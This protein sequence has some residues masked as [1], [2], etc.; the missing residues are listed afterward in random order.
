MSLEDT[1]NSKKGRKRKD[2]SDSV[3]L[4]NEGDDVSPNF[5]GIA[6]D[7]SAKKGKSKESSRSRNLSEDHAH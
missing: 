3:D 7:G 5:A 4:E 1:I 2:S 6:V